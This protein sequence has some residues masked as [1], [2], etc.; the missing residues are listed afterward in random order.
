[1]NTLHTLLERPGIHPASRMVRPP[2]SVR[3]VGA[4]L[5]SIV[6][7]L[8]LALLL[9]PWQQ[10]ALGTGRVIAFSPED[11]QQTVEAP[12]SGRVE[13][14]LVREGEAVEPGQV[15]AEIVDVDPER[16]SRLVQ[17]Q[18]AAGEQM[19]IVEAQIRSY[20]AKLEAER[21]A[22]DLAVAEAASKLRGLE[23][24]R[25]GDQAEADI[26]ALNATRLDALALE[27]IASTRDAE[28]GR[29]KRD[30]ARAALA[31]RDREIDAQRQA[32]AKVRADADAKVATVQADLESARAKLNDAGQKQLEADTRVARQQA[33]RIVAPRA[34]V[35]LRLYGGPGGALVKEG[36]ALLTLVP[37]ARTQ[38]LELWVDGNDL[39]LVESGQQVRLMFEGWPAIQLPGFPGAQAGTFAGRLAF[40]DATDDGAGKFRVVVLPD[41]DEPPWPD[42]DRLRQGVRVKGWILLG[43]VKLGYELWRRTNGFPP[44]PSVEKGDTSVPASAKKP[45]IPGSLK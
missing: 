7:A 28:V 15:L 21:A 27:G 41:A 5:G 31:A 38:A 43:Q 45:R 16:L 34:G 17:G 8:L 40:V 32:L 3:R 29:M 4:A 2:A 14:W 44:L 6:P 11:R 18:E 25:A 42:P 10:A 12:V 37:E 35:V 1:V 33:Q 26:E 13:R 23:Q 22:R 20:E 36:D 24:K 19:S 30:Q 39:P 9:V